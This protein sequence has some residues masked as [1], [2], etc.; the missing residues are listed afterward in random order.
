MFRRTGS[1]VT[2]GWLRAF[3]IGSNRHRV[4]YG[5]GRLARYPYNLTPTAEAAKAKAPA[6]TQQH[7]RAQ[8]DSGK[9]AGG[10]QESRDRG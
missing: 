5:G 1:R 6:R 10:K 8:K 7:Q 3:E 9:S 2:R 4:P